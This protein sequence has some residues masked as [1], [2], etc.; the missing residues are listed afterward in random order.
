MK[1]RISGE[2]RVVMEIDGILKRCG[3]QRNARDANGNYIFPPDPHKWHGGYDHVIHEGDHPIC[4]CGHEWHD[5]DCAACFN[6]MFS[7][8]MASHP[9]EAGT[10]E[11]DHEARE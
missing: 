11:L 3:L 7:F 10:I 5:G 8:D 9:A 2:C 6:S 4:K 1:K